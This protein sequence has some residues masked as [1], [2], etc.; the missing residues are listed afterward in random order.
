[1]TTDPRRKSKKLRPHWNIHH[2]REEVIRVAGRWG[3]AS[4]CARLYEAEVTAGRCPYT[5]FK[6]ALDVYDVPR[7]EPP[8]LPRSILKILY[9]RSFR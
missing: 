9:P 8:G 1:M 3:L 6:M 4:D 7:E 5:A 2:W